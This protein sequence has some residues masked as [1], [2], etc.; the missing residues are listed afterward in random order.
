[1]EGTLIAL[2]LTRYLGIRAVLTDEAQIHLE[3]E[4]D[5]MEPV[6]ELLRAIGEEVGPGHEAAIDAVRDPESGSTTAIVEVR[7]DLTHTEAMEV[8]RRIVGRPCPLRDAVP[9]RLV[10]S[11]LGR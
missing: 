4:L 10:V 6:R 3:G 8:E 1:M 9:P 11:I 2:I 5:L 7:V